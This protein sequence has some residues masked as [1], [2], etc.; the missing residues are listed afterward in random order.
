MKRLKGDASYKSLGISALRLQEL[1]SAKLQMITTLGKISVY[2]RQPSKVLPPCSKAIA[3]TIVA[4]A[5]QEIL[6]TLRN[7]KVHYRV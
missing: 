4:S 3:N 2:S 7:L 1:V 5:G 6:S